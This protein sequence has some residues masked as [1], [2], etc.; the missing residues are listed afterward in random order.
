[1][2]R[3]DLREILESISPRELVESKDPSDNI[4]RRKIRLEDFLRNDEKVCWGE[5]PFVCLNGLIS[6]VTA[7]LRFEVSRRV[8]G[9]GIALTRRRRRV[10]IWTN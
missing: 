4:V 10:F 3:N 5:I 7:H 1:M 2:D 9:G 6:F 8:L